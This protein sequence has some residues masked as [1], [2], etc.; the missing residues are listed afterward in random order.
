MNLKLESMR[1]IYDKYRKTPTTRP[2]GRKHAVWGY[3]GHFHL[4][5]AF[6]SVEN[7]TNIEEVI[8]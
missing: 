5:G 2:P 1:M 7:R 4:S 3:R 8:A 6:Y